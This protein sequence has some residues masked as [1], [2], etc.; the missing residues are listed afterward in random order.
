MFD[1][2]MG[3][4][5][6]RLVIATI[7][8]GIGFAML[9]GAFWLYRR[10]GGP[11]PFVRGG[12]N[13]QPRLQVL[14]AA[15]VDTRRRL[16]LIRRD[17]VEHLIMIG[18]PTDVVIESRIAQEQSATGQQEGFLP[19]E[20]I[21]PQT[22]LPE[23]EPRLAAPIEPRPL[24]MKQPEAKAA[25]TDPPMQPAEH[26]ASLDA[27]ENAL[28]AARSRVLPQDGRPGAQ[29]PSTPTSSPTS[30]VS[31]RQKQAAADFERVLQD[32]M[33]EN[34]AG[35]PPA[36]QRRLPP[37]DPSAP[38]LTGAT[39]EPSLQAEVARIF[40]EMS[41]EEHQERSTPERRSKPVKAPASR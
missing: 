27:A 24:P 37:R 30:E 25:R 14:D 6:S 22:A 29:S 7:G 11:S 39:R 34:P 38:P 4:Y 41:V 19:F 16:V 8:V 13:R 26:S 3:A 28:D 9:I 21:A 2:M 32:A 40:G 15:A 10:R 20:E 1:D 23:P 18:G 17:N 35:Q 5:G 33:G 36:Q 31:D 12:R